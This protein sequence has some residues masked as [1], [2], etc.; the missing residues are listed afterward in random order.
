MVIKVNILILFHVKLMKKKRLEIIKFTLIDA[1][2]LGSR[3]IF[4]NSLAK[5]LKSGL[6]TGF[7]NQQRSIIM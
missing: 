6:A 4:E 1:Y 5:V 2:L 7:S 3:H